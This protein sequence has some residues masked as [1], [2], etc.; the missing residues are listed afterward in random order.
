MIRAWRQSQQTQAVFASEHGVSVATLRNWLRR[1][2]SDGAGEATPPKFVEVDIGRLV[3]AEAPPRHG[4]WEFEI[5]LP[6]GRVV[7]VAPGTSV[8]RLRTVLEAVRC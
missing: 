2:N 5:R 4:S 7:A 8:E 6:C 1:A 3:G